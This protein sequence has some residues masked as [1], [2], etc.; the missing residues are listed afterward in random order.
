MGLLSMY[1]YHLCRVFIQGSLVSDGGSLKAPVWGT[2]NT[3]RSKV[4]LIFGP[5]IGLRH[6]ASCVVLPAEIGLN[7]D[8]AS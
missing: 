6:E 2:S 5:R 3:S 8:E 7:V 1:H 4:I